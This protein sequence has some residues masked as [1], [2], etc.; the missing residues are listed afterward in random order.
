MFSGR[1]T[2]SRCFPGYHTTHDHSHPG[3]SA[4]WARPRLVTGVGGMEGILSIT[5]SISF[6]PPFS[7]LLPWWLVRHLHWGGTCSIAFILPLCLWA[8]TLPSTICHIG[9]RRGCGRYA[10]SVAS[11]PL[12]TP[13]S[14]PFC[15]PLHLCLTVGSCSGRRHGP[16]SYGG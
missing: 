4:A 7:I 8:R 13:L 10:S 11:P 15:T 9:G 14:L 3:H 5:R 12:C 6:H 2:T 1:P 16:P